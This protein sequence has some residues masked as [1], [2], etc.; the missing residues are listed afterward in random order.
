MA[1][2]GDADRASIDHL[3]TLAQRNEALALEVGMLRERA[4]AQEILIAQL[5]RRVEAAEAERD[6]LRGAQERSAPAIANTPT[7]P[8]LLPAGMATTP[9]GRP[10]TRERWRR[11]LAIFV[12]LDDGIGTR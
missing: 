7:R 10:E 12:R 5:R 6:H 8:I 2:P 1:T 9:P 3:T 4:A 11:I